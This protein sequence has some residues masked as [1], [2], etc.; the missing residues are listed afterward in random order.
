MQNMITNTTPYLEQFKSFW[1]PDGNTGVHKARTEAI[2]QFMNAGFPTKQMEAW[3]FT[4]IASLLEEPFVPAQQVKLTQNVIDAF[5]PKGWEGA[6]LSVVN[7]HYDPSLSRL[8]GIEN[9]LTISPLKNLN[10]NF[11]YDDDAFS[12]LNKAYH[13]SGLILEVADNIVVDQ[14]ILILY[15]TTPD[16]GNRVVSSPLTQIHIGKNAR[17]TIVEDFRTLGS[18]LMWCNRLTE[19]FIDEKAQLQHSV[20]QM[21]NEHSFH[22]ARNAVIQKSNSRYHSVFFT[23][24]AQLARNTVSVQLDGQGI[25]SVVNGL[26]LAHSEQVVDNHTF[27]DHAQPNC[28]SHELFRGILQDK[29]RGVFSGKILVRED[30]QKTDAKQSNN[31]LLLSDDA[32]MDSMPQLEIYADD[33]KCTHGATIGQLDETALFYLQARGIPKQKAK[34]MLTYAF[35]RE[36]IEGVK[37][38]PVKELITQLLAD[39]LGHD[40]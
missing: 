36:V 40:I 22:I 29:S 34:G 30:A 27:I 24:G 9:Q 16:S 4:N 5:L 15:L 8:V 18:G 38:K 37:N 2:K 31:S 35:A 26:Y 11:R 25:T 17:A 6:V 1:P 3:R 20:L 12:S 32:R 10:N 13:G 39:R 33:V 14:D 7:G 28:E 23:F 21:Q 19:I